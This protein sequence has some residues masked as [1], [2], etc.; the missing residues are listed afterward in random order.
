VRVR[1]FAAEHTSPAYGCG[2]RTCEIAGSGSPGPVSIPFRGEGSGVGVRS[3]RGRRCRIGP[4][5]T[6]SGGGP[7]TWTRGSS[8]W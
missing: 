2:R 5:R 7:A 1:A 6:S 8:P 4:T 3:F